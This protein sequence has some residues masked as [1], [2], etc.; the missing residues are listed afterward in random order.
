MAGPGDVV[1]AVCGK[2]HV[3][4]YAPQ[5]IA[6]GRLGRL[7]YS[8][9]T[10]TG[11][12]YGL[13]PDICIN[14]RLKEYLTQGHGR[15]L[16]E[17]FYEAALPVYHGLWRRSV[18][19]RWRPASVFHI[20]SHGAGVCLVERARRDGARV[21]VECVN[22]HPAHRLAVLRREA[23]HWGV[24]FPKTDLYD[25][26]R[27]HLEEVAAADRLLVPS[28]IV[29]RSYRAAGVATR[30]SKIP[31]AA[32]LI[33]FFPQGAAK[34]SSQNGPLRV[35]CVGEVGLRKGQLY[36]LEAARRLGPGALDIT[37]VGV[38]SRTAAPAFARYAGVFRH[39]PRAPHSD[40]PRLLAAHD[41]FVLP[42]LE[43]GLSVSICEAM[44]AGRAVVATP[45][46]GAGEIIDDSVDGLIV[47]ER[48]VD[49]LA[50]ALAR[51][52]DNK[53]AAAQ[54]GHT[55]SEAARR[56]VN[57]DAYAE[58]LIAAYDMSCTEKAAA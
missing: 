19:A 51:L 44:A 35:I 57:W 30:V 32:N 21:V 48:D 17:R 20:I 50:E 25:R 22:T 33:Q 1:I 42:S 24:A 4:N 3:L 28:D 52:R 49:A 8:H 55:A 39:I 43:E 13:D 12:A 2:Y 34:S 46:S 10:G 29:A 18:A 6:A 23:E 15:L 37:L 54:M 58:A 26:E 47:P 36:L 31:Y 16:G 11:A 27:L 5:L 41:V 40:I 53:D 7:H 14:H 38:M 45:A 9:K 56:R